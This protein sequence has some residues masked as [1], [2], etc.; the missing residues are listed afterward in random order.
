MKEQNKE[1]VGFRGDTELCEEDLCAHIAAMLRLENI[2]ILLGAGASVCANGKTMSETWGYFS[3]KHQPDVKWLEVNGF[4]T[5]DCV[6]LSGDDTVYNIESILDALSIAIADGFRTEAERMPEYCQTQARLY[7]SLIAASELDEKWW[8][9]ETGPNV[10]TPELQYHRSVIQKLISSRQPGQPSPWIFTSN[11][12]LAIEWAADSIGVNIINGF[13]GSQSRRFSP[14]TFD[15]GFRN[16]RARG[17]ARFGCYNIYLA[18]LHGSLNWTEYNNELIELSP[19]AAWSNICEYKKGEEKSDKPPCSILAGRSKYFQT[20]GYSYGEIVRRYAEF[21]SQPQTA[22]LVFGYGFGD[23]HINRL[24]SL[25]LNNPTFH[26]VV[27]LP[28]FKDIQ[29]IDKIPLGARQLLFLMNP[30]ITFVGGE[31]AYFKNAGKY[32]PDPA[33]YDEDLANIQ[34]RIH[35]KNEHPVLPGEDK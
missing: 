32:L 7:K 21:V 33:I 26:L 25:A 12:D 9:S 15:L 23:S 18:K 10:E 20:I 30:R 11:F 14:Q 5:D 8:L 3:E 28:E 31:N 24:F 16:V 22:M 34:K 6:I 35:H 19:R 29:D 1:P 27:F 17:E 4:L 2:G 13:A